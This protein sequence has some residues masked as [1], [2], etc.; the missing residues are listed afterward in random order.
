MP[1]HL[2]AIS[3]RDFIIRSLAGGA[4]LVLSPDLLAAGK[5]TDPNSWVFLSDIHIA[6]DA[7]QVARGINM[8]DHFTRVSRDLLGLP[9][10]PAGMFITGDCAYNSGKVD[11]YAH[12]ADLLTPIRQGPVPVRL[13]LGN[14]DNRERFWQA[15]EQEKA[16]K[17]PL[18][19]RQ[20]ALVQTPRANWFVL[21]SLEQTLSTP[22]MLGQ[23]QLDWLAGALDAHPKKPALVLLHHNPGTMAN[24]S[25]LKDTNSLFEI[26]RPRQQVKAYIF[27]H[28][29]VWHVEQDPS[30]IHL[31]NLPPVAY[32]FREGDPAGWVHAT[33]EREGIRLEL[34]CID[35]ANKAHG[36]VARLLWR[37]A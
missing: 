34:R 31:I 17:R 27:G 30:G 11:D 29:H 19:D 10:L 13:A 32:I 6:A 14:H 24:V 3:R 26:I 15:L 35:P 18:A 20:V 9:K 16:A 2:P 37:G 7:S 33:L 25:G 4:A 12:I 36:Q 28:T 22:G 21:D 23:E 5:R 1:I 8:T